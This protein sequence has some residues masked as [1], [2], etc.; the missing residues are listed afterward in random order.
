MPWSITSRLLILLVG[1]AIAF[2]AG[3]SAQGWRLGEQIAQTERDHIAAVAAENEAHRLKE[4]ALTKRVEDARNESVKRET[5]LRRD[6]ANSRSAALGL[7]DQ[8]AD[9]RRGIPGLAADAVRERADTLAEL[10]GACAAEYRDM[11]ETADRHASETK[12]LTDAWPR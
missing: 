3:W 6:A 1:A 7:R 4:R 2:G 10:F 8:L 5:A 12:T 9:I 11:A